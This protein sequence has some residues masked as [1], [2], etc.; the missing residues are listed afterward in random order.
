MKKIEK[1]GHT[2]A[3]KFMRFPWGDADSV[4]VLDE[5]DELSHPNRA[6]PEDWWLRVGKPL[7]FTGFEW[8]AR[9][10]A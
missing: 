5:S 10:V 6:K 4:L 1:A 7:E 2:N 9:E 3:P 8:T